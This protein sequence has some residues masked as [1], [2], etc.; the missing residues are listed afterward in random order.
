MTT[1]GKL[2]SA[3]YC[4]ATDA[5]LGKGMDLFPAPKVTAST[6]IDTYLQKDGLEA[7]EITSG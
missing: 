3:T 5:M 2:D 6:L 7:S 1:K 4:L